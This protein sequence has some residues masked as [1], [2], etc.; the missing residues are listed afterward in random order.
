MKPLLSLLLTALLLSA[1]ITS[2]Y[3]TAVAGLR[4]SKSHVAA[5]GLTDGTLIL[6][7]ALHPRD[8]GFLV[9]VW[10]PRETLSPNDRTL[11]FLGFC[12]QSERQFIGLPFWFL[13]LTSAAAFFYFLKHP[14][15]PLPGHCPR[16]NYNL[17]AS[18]ERCP[19]C[20][21]PI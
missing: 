4:Y 19:E 8:P 2:H 18:K 14:T 12:Y 20:G 11:A 5:I 15:L 10:A 21:T 6:A 7:A 16:C 9:L 17:R 1:W 3:R 13:S